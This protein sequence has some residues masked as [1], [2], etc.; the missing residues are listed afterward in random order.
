MQDAPTKVW[1]F[2]G[3]DNQDEKLSEIKPPLLENSSLHDFYKIT[4]HWTAFLMQIVKVLRRK[5]L[6]ARAS[7]KCLSIGSWSTSSVRAAHSI[8]HRAARR[9][10]RRTPRAARRTSR[11]TPLAEAVAAALVVHLG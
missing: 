10:L 3:G 8:A 5:W 4:L 11:R 9:T 7:S 2:F 1:Q 6:V